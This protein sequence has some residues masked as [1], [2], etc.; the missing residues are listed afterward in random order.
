MSEPPLVS[1]IIPTKDRPKRLRRALE[2]VLAQTYPHWEAIVVDD[3]SQPA[4]SLEGLPTNISVLRVPLS[5]GVA[6]ARN[7]GLDHAKGSLIAFLDD[8]DAYLP[9]K[10]ALQVDYLQHNPGIHLVFSKVRIVDRHGGVR[11]HVVGGHTHNTLKN[12]S[13]FNIIHTNSVLFRREVIE[14]VRFD[15]RLEKYTDMQF[16]LAVS[17]Q[18]K[19]ACHPVTV[20]I[21]NHGYD[22]S[23]LSTPRYRRNY[24]NFRIICEIFEDYIKRHRRLRTRYFGRLAYQAL[25]CLDLRG[26]LRALGKLIV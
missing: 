14:T 16:F 11:H 7:L 13:F 15:E 1:V 18:F 24:R 2:S 17:L 26:A 3:G 5:K 4:V 19:I 12:F 22:P 10:L 8:D 23:Q 6:H 20:A 9:E 25:R 21:W